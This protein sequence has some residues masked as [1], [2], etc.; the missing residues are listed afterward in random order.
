MA[1]PFGV[2][3]AQL[4]AIAAIVSAILSPI[5]GALTGIW[6]YRRQQRE[7]INAAII[8][9]W[10]PDYVAGGTIEMPFLVIQNRADKPALISDV[11]FL[12]GTV[13]PMPTHGTALDYSDPTDLEFPYEIAAGATWRRRLNSYGAKAITDKA[14]KPQRIARRLGR[15]PVWLEIRTMAG[16]RIKL[17]ADDATP[18]E[19]RATWLKD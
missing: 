12:A 11:R 9:G 13:F 4:A 7:Q 17:R 8:W 3:G 2:S 6:T 16:S 19:N 18:W 5:I 14:T 15:S 1:Q 10:G